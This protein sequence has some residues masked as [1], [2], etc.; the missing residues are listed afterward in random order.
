MTSRPSRELYTVLGVT[1]RL[2]AFAGVLGTGGVV[3]EEQGEIGA[4]A[5][6]KPPWL[7]L[8]H[9]SEVAEWPAA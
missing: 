4:D 7:S 1:S 8:A 5:V 9:H 3:D 6:T 2:R